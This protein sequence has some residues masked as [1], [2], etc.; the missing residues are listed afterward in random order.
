MSTEPAKIEST[1]VDE[2]RHFR[3][4]HLNEDLGARTIRGGALTLTVQLLKFALSTAVTIV[5]ARLLMPQDYGFVGMVMVLVNLLTMF[6]YLG[7]PNATVKWRDL[8]HV[9]VSNLFWVNVR[10]Q[11]GDR[12]GGCSLLAPAGKVL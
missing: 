2:N 3:T 12:I 7:L 5:V 6:Q 9:Q 8:T 10:T 4:D 11:L 1:A